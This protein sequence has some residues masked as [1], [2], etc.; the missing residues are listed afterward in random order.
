MLLMQLFHSHRSFHCAVYEVH[1]CWVEE[2]RKYS[3]GMPIVL[4]RYVFIF[5]V[6]FVIPSQVESLQFN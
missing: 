3:Y 2:L 1:M 4:A 5:T 6:P